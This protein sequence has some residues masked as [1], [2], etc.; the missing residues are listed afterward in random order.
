ME[1]ETSA[2]NLLGQ[3]S[4]L[5]QKDREARPV[6]RIETSTRTHPA[7]EDDLHEVVCAGQ[8]G[9]YSWGLYSDISV[10]EAETYKITRLLEALWPSP[11]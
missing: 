6:V 8:G 4:M 9:D 5:L 2:P 1:A 11:S 3:L 10:A 7:N